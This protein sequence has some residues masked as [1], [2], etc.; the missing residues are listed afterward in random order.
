VPILPAPELQVKLS[1]RVFDHYRVAEA[2]ERELG[3]AHPQTLSA[4]AEHA[5]VLYNLGRLAEAEAEF[6]RVLAGR[7]RSGDADEEG[8]RDARRWLEATRRK[9]NRE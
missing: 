1:S 9:L 7:E 2:R 4:Y 8:I 5:V 6:S 3:A